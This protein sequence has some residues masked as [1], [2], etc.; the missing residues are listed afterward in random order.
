METVTKEYYEFVK[1]AEIVDQVDGI[2]LNNSNNIDYIVLP[3]NMD[4]EFYS[5]VTLDSKLSF[6]SNTVEKLVEASIE[7]SPIAVIVINLLDNEPKKHS[8][9][10]RLEIAFDLQNIL[11]TLEIT[12]YDFMLMS[13]GKYYSFL[14]SKII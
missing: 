3:M 2:L 11:N 1:Q 7:H 4:G 6:G 14:K 9:Q 5:G 12:L 13:V 10:A 8:I